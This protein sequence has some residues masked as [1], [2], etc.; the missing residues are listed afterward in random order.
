M[1]ETFLT[2]VIDSLIKLLKD[3]VKSLKGIHR[4]V[5]S[6]K[7]ELEII[8]SLLK[9]AN[10]REDREELSDA[11]KTWVKQLRE[12]ADRIEDVI[13]EYR[14]HVAQS[15]T[16]KRGLVGF[17]YKTSRRIKALK[18]RYPITSQ[19][20]DIKESLRRIKDAG[21][22]YGLSQSLGLQGSTSKTSYVEEHDTQLG[23][24]FVVEDNEYVDVPF[25][26]G[27]LKR[28][29][30]EEEPARMIISLVGQGGIG[31]TTLV[32]KVYD[33]VKHNF[34]C[35]VWITVSQSYHMEELLRV[36]MNQ[37]GQI[38]DSTTNQGL[39]TP[40]RQYLQTKRYVVV[41]D[42]VWDTNFLG[43]CET[44]FS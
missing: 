16:D 34:D 29:L 18:S 3:E 13:D 2:P 23:S 30:V 5:E 19:I 9:D 7:R 8:H 31:K 10:A 36:T 33:E 38:A 4:E 14:W 24:H 21:Q 25:V 32:K 6:L 15:T 42:D 17:L 35:S 43:N 20:Y 40:L 28:H 27:E 22:G 12:E 26:Q 37:I 44:C 11:V 1:A 39:I 41:F